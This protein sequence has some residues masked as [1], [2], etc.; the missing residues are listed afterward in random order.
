MRR[1]VRRVRGKSGAPAHLASVLLLLGELGLLARS[2]TG[3]ET[4]VSFRWAALREVPERTPRASSRC[5]T[6]APLFCVDTE[7]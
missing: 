4:R 2:L 1:L 6:W 3:E 7:S 5:W